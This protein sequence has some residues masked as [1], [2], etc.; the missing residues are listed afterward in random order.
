MLVLQSRM[1]LSFFVSRRCSGMA[2]QQNGQGCSL[3][4]HFGFHVPLRNV[5]HHAHHL[6]SASIVRLFKCSQAVPRL[7]H[8]DPLPGMGNGG[9]VDPVDPRDGW[10]DTLVCDQGEI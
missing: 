4:I 8:V 3:G 9:C 7:G 5:L 1:D 10:L 2:V 6:T